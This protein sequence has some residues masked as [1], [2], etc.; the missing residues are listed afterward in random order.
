[1]VDADTVDVL[2]HHEH[3]AVEFI[4][5]IVF[6]GGGV[7]IIGV[8]LFEREDE[9]GFDVGLLLAD[10][11][12]TRSVNLSEESSVTEVRSLSVDRYVETE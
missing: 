9:L 7:V 11:V 1:M 6:H 10:D 12:L 3:Q 4:G 8:E 2:E 5:L